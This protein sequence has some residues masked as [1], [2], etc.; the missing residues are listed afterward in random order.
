MCPQFLIPLLT[1]AMSL[2]SSLL[3]DK[4]AGPPKATAPPVEDTANKQ[5][6]VVKIG[7]PIAEDPSKIP[8]STTGNVT[9]QRIFGRPVGGLGKSGLSI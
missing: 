6:A 9:E 7:D 5:A 1:G 2:G 8:G 3:G 4:P